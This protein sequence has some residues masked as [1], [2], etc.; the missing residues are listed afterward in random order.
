MDTNVQNFLHIFW[1]HILVVNWWKHSTEVWKWNR[2]QTCKRK[3]VGP[4]WNLLVILAKWISANVVTKVLQWYYLC[5][6]RI[7]KVWQNNAGTRSDC[8]KAS[9]RKLCFGI[10][11]IVLDGKVNPSVKFLCFCLV[12]MRQNHRVCVWNPIS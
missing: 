1:I 8:L 3:K 7:T 6:T 9:L 10:S 12:L 4:P 5:I 2:K 11:R